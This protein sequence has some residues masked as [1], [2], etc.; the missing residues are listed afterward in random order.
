MFIKINHPDTGELVELER[1]QTYNLDEAEFY[2]SRCTHP[3]QQPR[4]RNIAGGRS[5]I[6]M[7]CQTCG[8]FVGSAI[9]KAQV[10]PNTPN[11]DLQLNASY[12]QT[13]ELT[14][15]AIIRKHLLLQDTQSDNWWANYSKYVK[16]EMW[17]SRRK[18]VLDRA[19]RVCEGCGER[20]ATIAHHKTYAHVCNELLFELVAL[21]NGCHRLVHN[22]Q[23][24]LP[25]SGCRFASTSEGLDWCV[26]FDGPALEALSPR[27]PCG[28]NARALSPLR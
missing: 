4:R 3:N 19:N 28:P 2:R 12:N 24:E 5:A 21:C 22:I 8:E 23:G 11:A 6:Y 1:T 27:G 10:P 15:Q 9:P 18:K 13:R 20:P 16:T 25:C 26:N 14:H 17:A 7:Q